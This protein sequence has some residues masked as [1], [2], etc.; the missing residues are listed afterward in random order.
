LDRPKLRWENNIKIDIEEVGRSF[1]VLLKLA[2][3]RD[4][5]QALVCK[6]INFRVP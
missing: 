5:W 1:G 3:V 4:S 2:Q 6:V